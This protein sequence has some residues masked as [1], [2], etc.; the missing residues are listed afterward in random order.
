MCTERVV[1]G[2]EEG[3]GWTDA[4]DF[5]SYTLPEC[6]SLN[7]HLSERERE[8]GTPESNTYGAQLKWAEVF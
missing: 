6:L 1:R 2:A 5:N 8:A 4:C 7:H 3:C